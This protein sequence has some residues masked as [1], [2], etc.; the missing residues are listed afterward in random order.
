MVSGWISLE[1]LLPLKAFSSLCPNQAGMIPY[2]ALPLI[3]THTHSHIYTHTDVQNKTWLFTKPENPERSPI[4]PFKDCLKFPHRC[5][6]LLFLFYVGVFFPCSFPPILDRQCDTSFSYPPTLTHPSISIATITGIKVSQGQV[7]RKVL[8]G[9]EREGDV[10]PKMFCVC[11]MANKHNYTKLRYFRWK[12][13]S[14]LLDNET[15]M[16]ISEILEIIFI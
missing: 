11:V 6:C 3:Q 13:N 14:F 5:S 15:Q 9:E 2:P 12:G 16:I 7:W 10:E 1:S 8:E 4:L